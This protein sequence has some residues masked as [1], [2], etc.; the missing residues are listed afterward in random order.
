MLIHSLHPSYPAWRSRRSR[1][2]GRM[3][4]VATPRSAVKTSPYWVALSTRH[5]LH[6]TSNL[7][8]FPEDWLQR[9]PE[10][11]WKFG[12]NNGDL[13]CFNYLS[14]NNIRIVWLGSCGF[15]INNG[16][17]L[18]WDIPR[19]MVIPSTLMTIPG[20]VSSDQSS[21]QKIY[22]LKWKNR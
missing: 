12:D 9:S 6:C 13:K 5:G 14:I 2:S 15:R 1:R 18:T 19:V 11:A 22:R 17:Y 20:P 21:V 8:C 16:H 10:L 3:D 7:S 4:Y